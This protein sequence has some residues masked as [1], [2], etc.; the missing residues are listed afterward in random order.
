MREAARVQLAAGK[1]KKKNRGLLPYIFEAQWRRHT[2]ARYNCGTE[3][4]VVE[5]DAESRR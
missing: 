3:K 1:K 5:F 4:L 2:H